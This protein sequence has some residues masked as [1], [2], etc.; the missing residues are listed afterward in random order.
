MSRHI[1]HP[2]ITTTMASSNS[3]SKSHNSNNADKYLYKKRKQQSVDSAANAKKKKPSQRR[4]A[5]IVQEGKQIW[6]Q[7]RL[8]QLS[9]DEKQKLVDQLK[10]IVG[11]KAAEIALQHDGSRLVQSV[12][13]FGSDDDRQMIVAQFQTT[14][15]PDL[16]KSQ[17]G[18][19]CILKLLK[20][21]HGD[22]TFLKKNLRGHVAKL[23]VHSIGSRVVQA[24]LTNDHHQNT[25]APLQYE[26]YGPH[27]LLV[28]D[29]LPKKHPSLKHVLE[30]VPDKRDVVLDYCRN[31]IV[32]KGLQKQLYGLSFFQDYLCEFM[33]HIPTFEIR[34]LAATMADHAIH[35]VSTKTGTKVVCELFA[36]GT[37]KTRKHLL[38]SLKGYAKSAL[39]HRDAY[40]AILRACRV[41]DD[42]VSVQKNLLAELQEAS[43]LE[44][45]LLNDFGSKLLSMLLHTTGNSNSSSLNPKHFDPYE[46]SVLHESPVV[47][48]DG[49]E[50]PT[51][52][53]DPQLRSRELLA[54]LQEPLLDVCNKQAAKLLTSIPGSSVLRDVCLQ[55]KATSV[56]ESILEA[57]QSNPALF[58]DKVGHRTLKLLNKQSPQF[59]NL[60]CDAFADNFM[61]VC[62]ASNRGAF[63]VSALSESHPELLAKH[64]DRSK[65]K[66]L[67]EKAEGPTAGYEA[68]LKVF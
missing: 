38:K 66:L 23:A 46:L 27:T 31:H 52:K 50:V 9:K 60:F 18:H 11:D 41:C 14:S 44:S 20:Y 33:Q 5:D 17:Y 2:F 26:L 55:L 30:K 1:S 45:V 7:L 47:L 16:C 63:V 54:Y 61:E 32:Q 22:V 4:H 37:A 48:E 34:E 67:V 24:L 10:E 13:Q 53:K 65:L 68:L 64:L 21:Y 62:C 3:S 29:D 15:L 59:A 39:L 58:E 51:S 40:L 42:T 56:M 35:L 8:K 25:L 12:L 43:A 57:A 36:Y 6:N 19:F 28:L 49:R